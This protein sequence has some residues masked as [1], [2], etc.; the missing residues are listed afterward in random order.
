M[1]DIYIYTY[2][3]ICIQRERTPRESERWS[4]GE[5]EPERKM[6]CGCVTDSC[7]LPSDLASLSVLSLSLLS[8][9]LSLSLL[10]RASSLFLS[11]Y[12]L[13]I[14]AYML[15]IHTHTHMCVCVCV[16]FILGTLMMKDRAVR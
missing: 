1:H 14:Y 4:D 3:H 11:L 10:S 9:S 13:Y 7:V 6:L 8:L 2:I 5:R 15:S 12:I 16:C